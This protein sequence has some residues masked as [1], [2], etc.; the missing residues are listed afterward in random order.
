MQF[1]EDPDA[2]T[3]SKDDWATW[4]R[5]E[6]KKMSKTVEPEIDLDHSWDGDEA[7]TTTGASWSAGLKEIDSEAQTKTDARNLI[8]EK[9][10]KKH[11]GKTL[12]FVLDTD[13]QY[14]DWAIGIVRACTHLAR[15]QRCASLTASH[16]A[17]ARRALH[18]GNQNLMTAL[19]GDIGHRLGAFKEDC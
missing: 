1:A 11:A 18:L 17:R 10:L 2:A 13:C 15:R 7:S 6:K 3:W 14:L 5:S 12:G 9:P 19:F 16:R 4:A 8:V